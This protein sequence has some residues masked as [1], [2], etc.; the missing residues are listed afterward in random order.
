M[1]GHSKWSS[2]KHKKAAADSKRGKIFTRLL[3]EIAVAARAGGGDP[4]KN[5]RLR[6]AMQDARSQNMPADNIKRAIL[7]GTGQ[8]EGAAYEE[9]TYEG[10]GPGGIALYLQIVSDNKN[11]TISEIRHIFSK[12]N[13]RIGENG[14]V[15]WMFKQMGYLDIEKEKS[16]EEQLMDLALSAGAE[17][18]KD[19]GSIWEIV[20]K[21]EAY[22]KVLE[23]VKAAGIEIADSNVGYL[24]Q[25]YVKLEGKDAQQALKLVDELEE[26]DDVQNVYS[27]FD[28][29]EEEIAKF[30]TA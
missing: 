28:I 19:D 4:D 1:S 14:C 10:Y 12:N 6:K 5:A 29:D 24:P 9:L 13:G 11:R 3:R 25:N 21:P 26:H 7:K 8:L 18:I 2:I 23:A 30:G 17:D 20:T 27:N 16:S 15:A 22:E